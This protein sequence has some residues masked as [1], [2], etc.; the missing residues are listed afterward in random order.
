MVHLNQ[1]ETHYVG[2]G[3]LR[4]GANHF[5]N[6]LA[7][8]KDGNAYVTGSFAPRCCIAVGGE[9]GPRQ[10]AVA[11]GAVRAAGEAPRTAR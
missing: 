10:Q 9:L 2:L 5:A 6:D 4:P 8:D 7:V 11:A 3:G 1:A